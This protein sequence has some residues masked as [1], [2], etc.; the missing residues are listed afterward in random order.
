M[1]CLLIRKRVLL[2]LFLS[3]FPRYEPPPMAHLGGGTMQTQGAW[4]G[5]PGHKDG[6][7]PP[8]M[9]RQPVSRSMVYASN[10]KDG[11]PPPPTRIPYE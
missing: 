5:K 3:F 8:F 9:P 4:N 6:V 2:T 10:S 11:V 1:L 7:P